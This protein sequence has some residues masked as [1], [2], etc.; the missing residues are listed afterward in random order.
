M[1]QK[2]PECTSGTEI[3]KVSGGGVGACPQTLLRCGGLTSTK[4]PGNGW[5]L[6]MPLSVTTPKAWSFHSISYIL[7]LKIFYTCESITVWCHIFYHAALCW[8]LPPLLSWYRTLEWL[9]YTIA[10]LCKKPWQLLC[11][12][13]RLHV[14]I[15][16]AFSLLFCI[17][18]AIKNWSQEKPENEANQR[19]LLLNVYQFRAYLAKSS[20]TVCI[21]VRHTKTTP[22]FCGNYKYC[23]QL[24]WLSHIIP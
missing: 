4:W 10:C 1:P 15:N 22:T 11:L 5:S 13:C 12:C 24:V 23:T 7:E 14:K 20:Y 16:Q 6:A 17:L 18:Q 2:T 19:V 21:E 8:H 9:L 3:F